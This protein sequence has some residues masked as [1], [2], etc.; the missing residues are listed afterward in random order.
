MSQAALKRIRKPAKAQKP[1]ARKRVTA[2]PATF[3]NIVFARHIVFADHIK[4]TLGWSHAF[5][6]TG[7][8]KSCD[9][10]AK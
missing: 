7:G 2:S 10:F 8:A 1:A 3:V 4:N 9:D 5:A 6:I